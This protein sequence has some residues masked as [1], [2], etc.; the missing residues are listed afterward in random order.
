[1]GAMVLTFPANKVSCTRN[2]EVRT[3]AIGLPLW[4]DFVIGRRMMPVEILLLW[5]FLLSFLGKGEVLNMK[6]DSKQ[7]KL[8]T[9]LSTVGITW[10]PT[11]TQRASVTLH[12]IVRLIFVTPCTV[13]YNYFQI[14]P[15]K[16]FEVMETCFAVRWILPRWETSGFDTKDRYWC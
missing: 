11:I 9:V 15:P 14:S 13:L 16:I 12:L 8:P 7:G 2:Q 6:L 10:A 4:V 1:M 3:A 5:A